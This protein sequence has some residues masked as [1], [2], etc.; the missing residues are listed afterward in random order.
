MADAA[1]EE[2]ADTD[3]DGVFAGKLQDAVDDRIKDTGIRAGTE[4]QDGKDEHDACGNDAAQALAHIICAE[5][6]KCLGKAGAERDDRL[7]ISSSGLFGSSLCGLDD[8][9]G[10]IDECC[11]EAGDGGNKDQSY[12]GRDLLA[13]DQCQHQQ[14]G[15]ES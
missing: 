5:D 9:I 3:L 1:D 15:D 14:N 13:H 6:G 2:G 11:D 10:G 12:K 8:D 7:N 4:K